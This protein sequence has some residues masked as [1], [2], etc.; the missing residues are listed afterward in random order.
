M[1]QNFKNA[2]ILVFSTKEKCKLI[3]D[4]V[5]KE[6]SRH[7]QPTNPV[8]N[9][10]E[11]FKDNFYLPLIKAIENGNNGF[12]DLKNIIPEFVNSLENDEKIYYLNTLGENVL[13]QL[14]N[15][16]GKNTKQPDKPNHLTSDTFSTSTQM[17]LGTSPKYFMLKRK[18]ISNN[19]ND[20]V[21][22]KNS[23][24]PCSNNSSPRGVWCMS[25]APQQSN[26]I[27]KPTPKNS[28]ENVDFDIVGY[29]QNGI[30]D[31]KLLVFTSNERKQCYEFIHIW[32]SFNLLHC[33]K[34]LAQKKHTIIKATINDDGSKSYDFGT[35]KHFCEPTEYLPGNYQSSLIIKSSNFKLVKRQ[36]GGKMSPLLII[37][38]SDGRN[39]CYKLGFDSYH[40]MF[41][42]YECKKQGR[43]LT[44]R[45][46]QYE[47]KTTIEYNRFEHICQP[48]KYNA[49]S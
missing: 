25:G 15:S 33:I 4:A 47:G 8:I 30:F 7:S 20:M 23:K 36:F 11:I 3:Y 44:A 18:N 37:F 12:Q 38:A 34:C 16:I 32:G 5:I 10:N 48:Q 2:L 43:K 35:E 49:E 45:F 41:S 27:D 1:N 6:K 26:A 19:D 14:H 31:K 28:P 22:P 42:C 21:P 40:N 13:V 9:E 24:K 46:V 29:F 17:H 39:M